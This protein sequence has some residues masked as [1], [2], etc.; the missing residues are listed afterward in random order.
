LVVLDRLEDEHRDEPVGLHLVVGIGRE[1]LDA[2]WPPLVALGALELPG[3][4]G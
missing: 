3:A 2:P 1:R 4:P